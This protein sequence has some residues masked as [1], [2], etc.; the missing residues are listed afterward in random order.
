MRVRYINGY[1]VCMSWAY[2]GKFY[3]GE[4]LELDSKGYPF[5]STAKCLFPAVEMKNNFREA[6]KNEIKLKKDKNEKDA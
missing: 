2:G 6:Y 3:K 4:V 1:A 5:N